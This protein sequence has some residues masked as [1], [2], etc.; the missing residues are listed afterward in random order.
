MRVLA[1]M[2][3]KAENASFSVS[4]ESIGDISRE[5]VD[6]AI[7]DLFSIARSSIL[8]Q[9]NGQETIAPEP[10][11]NGNGNGKQDDYSR[12]TS[13]QKSLIIKLAKERGQFISGL[14][15][16]SKADASHIIEDLMSVA[17]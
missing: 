16:M 11:K 2:T 13:K 17:A 5:K 9:L 4:V 7:D 1:N 8:R 10:K 6:S 12:C 3:Q 14:K 15:D